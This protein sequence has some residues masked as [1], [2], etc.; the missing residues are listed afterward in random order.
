MIRELAD[1]LDQP[2]AIKTIEM[3]SA[4]KVAEADAALKETG[5]TKAP[6]A[7][8]VSFSVL[9]H[10]KEVKGLLR[11]VTGDDSAY[12]SILADA[13][14]KKSNEISDDA[15]ARRIWKLMAT[16][17]NRLKQNAEL[18]KTLEHASEVIGMRALTD[19]LGV[20]GCEKLEDVLSL[21]GDPL[22]AFLAELKEKVDERKGAVK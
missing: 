11:E 20:H 12:Y 8:G 18:M 9:G 3:R 15:T 22:A 10:F 21:G 16:E 17:H 7:G 2:P 4:A 6:K 5:K 14:Y 19:L 1:T 13:G